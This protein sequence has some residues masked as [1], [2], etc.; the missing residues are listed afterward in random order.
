MIDIGTIIFGKDVGGEVKLASL[1]RD[2]FKKIK[3]RMKPEEVSK[4]LGEPESRDGGAL[5]VYRYHLS[6]G[7]QIRI[8]MGPDLLW[9]K[10]ILEGAERELSLT[11]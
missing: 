11:K 3:K 7:T 5:M 8:G 4:I 1:T 9:A 2:L 6:D 10:E